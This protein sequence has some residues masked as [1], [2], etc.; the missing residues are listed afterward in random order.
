MKLSKSIIK[1]YGISKKAWAVARG[2]TRGKTKM[3]KSKGKKRGSFGRSGDSSLMM[4]ATAAAVYGATRPMIEAKIQPFTAKLP[5]GN[6]ADEVALG[7]VGYL[8]A[9]GK[10][11][12]VKGKMARS[13][14]KAILIIE[15]ARVGSGV[16]SQL[17]R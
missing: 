14:G 4:T 9:S 7:V 17:I 15:A 16:G 6:Y 12:L 8:L 5:L 10:M 2:Q 3:A 1:K 13:A 11:P